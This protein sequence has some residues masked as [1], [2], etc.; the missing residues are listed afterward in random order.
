MD[1]RHA[2]LLTGTSSAPFQK[3][4]TI[5]PIKVREFAGADE[6]ALA[7]KCFAMQAAVSPRS[8]SSG[9]QWRMK[10]EG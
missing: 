8:F 3:K 1:E 2:R 10:L 6:P 5:L 4:R 7:E 9:A